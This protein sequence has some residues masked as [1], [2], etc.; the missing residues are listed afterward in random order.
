VWSLLLLVVVITI[1]AMFVSSQVEDFI[2]DPAN[3]VEVRTLVFESWGTC[4][5]AIVTMFEI[6]LANWGPHCR[7]LMNRVDEWWAL[8]FLAYK[9]SIGFAVVQVIT[10]V[11]IQQTFKVASRDE[12][13]MIAEKKAASKAYIKNLGHLFEKLD[14]SGDGFITQ[15]EFESV[16]TDKKVRTWFAS[17][18]VNVS[19]AS[20]LFELLDDGDGAIM[21]TEFIDAITNLNGAARGTDMLAL[22]RDLRKLTKE[23]GNISTIFGPLED[24]PSSKWRSPPFDPPEDDLDL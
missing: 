15:D 7:L 18:D 13:V 23:V 22:T 5:R 2:T 19:E 10:A 8:F 14:K 16:L 1:I 24:A 20:R 12:E 4:T 9:C 11:F 21:R 3:D 6:T 17:I